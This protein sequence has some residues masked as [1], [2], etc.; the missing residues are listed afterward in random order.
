MKKK[1]FIKEF[2]ATLRGHMLIGNPL[3]CSKI[4][5]YG[6]NKVYR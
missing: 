3:W 6:H 1:N 5:L 4:D 2:A